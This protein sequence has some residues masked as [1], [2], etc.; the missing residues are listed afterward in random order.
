MVFSSI[1]PVYYSP[2][3]HERNIEWWVRVFKLTKVTMVLNIEQSTL[4][5][6]PAQLS[7]HTTDMIRPISL[8]GPN[9]RQRIAKLLG[10]VPLLIVQCAHYKK[11]NMFACSFSRRTKILIDWKSQYCPKKII[12]VIQRVVSFFFFF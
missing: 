4:A 2:S 6:G 11:S 7:A 10:I 5:L 1:R 12:K 9:D 3:T 8:F